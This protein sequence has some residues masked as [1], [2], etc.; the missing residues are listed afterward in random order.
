[1]TLESTKADDIALAIEEAIVSGELA[2]GTVLRQEHL[3][4]QFQV[5]R[6]PI[7]EALRRLA[8]LGLVSF[9]PNRGVRVRTLSR[10]DLHEA[11]LVRAELESLATSLAAGRITDEELA[12]L[13]E[14]ENRFAALAQEM[15]GRDPGGHRREV[16]AQW[17]RANHAFHDVIYRAADAPLVE[18]M[19]K[20]ARRTFS[21]PAVWAPGDEVL[22]ELYDRNVLEHR[23]IRQALQARSAEGARALAHEHVMHSFELLDTILEHVGQQ[24]RDWHS[25]RSGR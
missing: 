12:E 10:E 5:S 17:M 7:R 1:V 13:E 16:S 18:Q 21:G 11:F 25:V 9:V 23:A 15:R 2:P 22:D 19:A 24:P 20:S 8:A 3:S 14:A 4:E 6:T